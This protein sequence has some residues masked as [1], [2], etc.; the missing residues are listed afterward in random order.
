VHK[1]IIIIIII[2][3][4]SPVQC[5]DAA[6][7]V[8]GGLP[9]GFALHLVNQTKAKNAAEVNDR[10]LSHVIMIIF[11]SQRQQTPVGESLLWLTQLHNN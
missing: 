11:F 5:V 9:T 10:K 8:Q 7:F 1:H 4:A 2:L 3:A 6:L